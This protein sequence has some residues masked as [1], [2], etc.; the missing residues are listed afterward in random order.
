MSS[1]PVPAARMEGISCPSLSSCLH[2]GSSQRSLALLMLIKWQQWRGALL[3]P[4]L[5]QVSLYW[6]GVPPPLPAWGPEVLALLCCVGS[7]CPSVCCREACGVLLSFPSAACESQK[8]GTL[9]APQNVNLRSKKYGAKV[10]TASCGG[11]ASLPLEEGGL[12]AGGMGLVGTSLS[13]V[14]KG[15]CLCWLPLPVHMQHSAEHP[16]MNWLGQG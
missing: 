2:L 7:L 6:S 9:K 3:W 14:M 15:V 10:Q 11:A 8:R 12:G 13:C 16:W 5:L 1:S 4:T